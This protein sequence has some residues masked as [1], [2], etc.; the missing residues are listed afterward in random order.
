M[1]YLPNFREG[2]CLFTSGVIFMCKEHF[3]DTFITLEGPVFPLLFP[4]T[5]NSFWC[6]LESP[7]AIYSS[8]AMKHGWQEE[9]GP[10]AC[11]TRLRLRSVRGSAPCLGPK[12]PSWDHVFLEDLPGLDS[13]GHFLSKGLEQC[14]PKCSLQMSFIRNTWGRLAK[15][16]DSQVLPQTFRIRLSEGE[17]LQAHSDNSAHESWRTLVLNLPMLIRC[18]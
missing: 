11:G 10:R 8:P 2:M 7:A 1:S 18:N 17:F 6:L 15:V 13:S 3:W 9:N 16:I 4:Y 5:D 12:W 14:F